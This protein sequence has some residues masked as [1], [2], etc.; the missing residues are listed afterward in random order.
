MLPL[1]VSGSKPPARSRERLMAAIANE[2]QRTRVRPIRPR[3]S[4]LITSGWTAAAA[5]IIIVFFLLHQREDLRQR[6]VSLEADVAAQRGQ[7]LEAKDLLETLTSADAEHF[8][9]V[10]GKTPLPP[11]GKVIY[12]RARGTLVF[13]ASNIPTPPPRT[14][15]ELWL[16]PT[17]GAPV[18]AG[19]FKPRPDGTATIVRPPLPPGVE[20]KTF[21]ITIEP[22][23]G[24]SAPTS[25][26]ILVGIP[27]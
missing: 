10:G 23:A 8:T 12:V 26:P 27:G 24:S 9:L 4:W 22:E 20:A 14:T 19:L 18:P 25:R 17:S 5:A 13:L 15:Y 21:A 1:S 16:I 6:I 2:P 11:H 7:L 3:S